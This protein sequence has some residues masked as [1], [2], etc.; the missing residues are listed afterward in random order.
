MKKTTILLWAPVFAVFACSGGQPGGNDNLDPRAIQLANRLGIEYP[1]LSSESDFPLATCH[2]FTIVPVQVFD[3][4]YSQFGNKTDR[5]K[6]WTPGMLKRSVES[7]TEKVARQKLLYLAALKAGVEASKAEV[8][9]LLQNRYDAAGGK[10]KFIEYLTVTSINMEDVMETLQQHITIDKYVNETIHGQIHLTE[11]DLI[12]AYQEDKV[13]TVRHILLSTE[14]KTLEEKAEIRA[15]LEE[16][17]QE[18]LGGENFADLALQY[19]EDVASKRRG[20]LYPNIRRG[21]MVG[22]FE[23]QAFSLPVGEISEVFE[24]TYGY[25]I[26]VVEE[27]LKEERPLSEVRSELRAWLMQYRQNQGLETLLSTLYQDQELTFTPLPF[28]GDEEELPP[29]DIVF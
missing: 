3:Y 27:R 21:E 12:R 6:V 13:A 18:A 23:S 25:H 2:A 7:T 5:M 10:E 1:I 29:N 9:S 20:G 15:R 14:N 8:D 28:G 11:T 19:T 4:M 16:I 24:T 22:P 26:M 17:R